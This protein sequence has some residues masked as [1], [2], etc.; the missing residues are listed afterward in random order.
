MLYII[1]KNIW[2][3]QSRKPNDTN[4]KKGFNKYYNQYNHCKMLYNK[5]IKQRTFMIEEQLQKK[6]IGLFVIE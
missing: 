3:T 6:A 1:I 5:D 4:K 2:K